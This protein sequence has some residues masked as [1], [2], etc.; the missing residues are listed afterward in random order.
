M[1]TEC[2]HLIDEENKIRRWW[3]C[4][5]SFITLFIILRSYTGSGNQFNQVYWALFI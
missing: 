1:E 4:Y 2:L 5:K 3:K